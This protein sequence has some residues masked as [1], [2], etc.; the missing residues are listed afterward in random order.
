MRGGVYFPGI[1]RFATCHDTS[2]LLACG[3]PDGVD[4]TDR[5]RLVILW[6][7]LLA[8]LIIIWISTDVGTILLNAENAP[9]ALASAAFA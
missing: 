3:R 9:I 7:G 6:R 5:Q 1:A 2:L 8:E 4:L